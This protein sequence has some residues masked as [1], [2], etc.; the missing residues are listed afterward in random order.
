MG[1]TVKLISKVSEGTWS[2]EGT[3][4]SSKFSAPADVLIKETPEG[5]R[6]HL[7]SSLKI[8]KIDGR[9][10]LAWINAKPV[11]IE[12]AKK[13]AEISFS[14]FHVSLKNSK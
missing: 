4:S 5:A 11:A 14:G 10:V 13:G 3:F 2:A 6:L 9:E 1:L 8:S 7:D 12:K